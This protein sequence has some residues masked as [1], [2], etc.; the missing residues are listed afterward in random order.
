MTV[1]RYGGTAI[2]HGMAWGWR[3]LSPRWKGLW[4]G[5][6][7][8]PLNY[9]E[10]LMA[11]AM[12]VLTD[13]EHVFWRRERFNSSQGSTSDYG[14]HGRIGWGRLHQGYNSGAPITVRSDGED[15][16]DSRLAL[17]CTNVK[18][19]GI[20][21]YT[22]ML[23]VNTPALQDLFRNC[24]S[25]PAFF[26]ESPTSDDLQGIFETIANDLAQLRIAQ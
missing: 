19:A 21:V 12:I 3:A 8:L 17:L 10:P 5:D 16:L 13:G 24:A 25:N 6:P 11:K 2:K 14:S 22:I 23:Q 1:W 26:F 15:E 9:D 7:T 4:G 18:A 20:S